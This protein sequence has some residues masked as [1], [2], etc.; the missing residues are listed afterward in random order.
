MS[1]V[2]DAYEQLVGR[3]LTLAPGT[4]LPGERVLTAELDVNRQAVREALQR[5][6]ADG[7]VT[8]QH[9]G[10]TRVRDFRQTGAL[11]LLPRLI[12][13]DDN[14]LDRGVIRSVLEMRT[15]LAPDVAR[16]AA[17]RASADHVVAIDACVTALRDPA[18]T[19]ARRSHVN[20]DLWDALVDAA[21][22]IA[23]R[24]AYNSLRQC[25]EPVAELLAGVLVEELHD[26]AGRGRLL[27]AVRAGNG[28][29]AARAAARHLASS[30]EALTALLAD[31]PE[32]VAR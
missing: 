14:R 19:D 8:I 32:E 23:Y 17:L 29:A 20:L 28:D 5:L 21:D 18:T 9:G 10:A 13:T 4:K 12:F 16:F 31:L 24:F 11:H 22:N 7:L 30:T 1:R 6:E 2:D 3:V 26:D 27:A 25:F 15:C